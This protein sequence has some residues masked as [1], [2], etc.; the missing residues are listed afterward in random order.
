MIRILR[1]QHLCE[2]PRR[3]DALVDHLRRHRCL[4]QCLALHARPLAAHMPLDLEHTRRVVELLA[5]VL[6]DAL[7]LTAAVADRVRPARGELDARQA[8]R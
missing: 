5:D 8:R 6:A 3:R 7:Q 1:H 4:D 2:Q